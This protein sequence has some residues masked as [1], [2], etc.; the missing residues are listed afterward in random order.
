MS[1]GYDHHQQTQRMTQCFF[2][3]FMHLADSISLYNTHEDMAERG[4]SHTD[5]ILI[6]NSILSKLRKDDTF[7]DL[8]LK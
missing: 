7:L 8:T 2:R 4:G 1:K 6:I 5:S 3:V